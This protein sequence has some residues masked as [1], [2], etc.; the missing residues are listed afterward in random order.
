[1]CSP[2]VRSV[3]IS[4]WITLLLSLVQSLVPPWH[5]CASLQACIPRIVVG[6]PTG[7][8]PI[9]GLLVLHGDP[10][11][12]TLALAALLQAQLLGPSSKLPKH[13]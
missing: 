11:S 7:S 12:A 2:A 8:V 5:S 6:S 10:L 4:L 13:S 3:E 1:M 9:V